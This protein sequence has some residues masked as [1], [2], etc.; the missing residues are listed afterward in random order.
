MDSQ[1][2]S[3]NETNNEH[4]VLSTLTSLQDMMQQDSKSFGNILPNFL[5]VW[6]DLGAGRY[7]PMPKSQVRMNIR[8]KALGCVEYCVKCLEAKDVML[9]RKE[10]LKKLTIPLDDHKRLVRKAA[11]DAKNNWC[12]AN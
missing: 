9:L 6:L 8:I 4:L 12:L 5:N 3:Q 11:V 7:S 1:I 10:V 2:K